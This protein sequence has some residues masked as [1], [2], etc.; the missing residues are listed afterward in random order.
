MKVFNRA[1]LPDSIIYNGHI[2]K[3][4]PVATV[5]IKLGAN[6]KTNGMIEV[7]VLASNLKGKKD[8][9][10]KPY[11]AQKYYFLKQRK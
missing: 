9:H 2:Y 3:L 8:E 7:R 5:A 6:Y 4:S 10:G 11:Q 1:S